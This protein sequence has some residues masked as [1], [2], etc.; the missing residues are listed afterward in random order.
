MKIAVIGAGAAGFFG[1]LSCAHHFPEHEII[2]FEKTHKLL[3]KVKISGG[4]RCNVTNSKFDINQLHEFY[5]RGAKELKKTFVQFNHLDTIKWFESRGVEIIAEADG[6]M[7]PKSNSSQTIIDCLTD[8]VK[9]HN[10]SIVQGT[11]LLSV[12]LLSNN[13]FELMFSNDNKYQC[14]RILIATG[15]NSHNSAYDWLRKLN[16]KIQEPVPSLFTFN[17][18]DTIM[19]GLQGVV[20]KNAVVKIK[21]TKFA[22]QGITLITHWGYSG[23][24]VLR[25]SAWAARALHEMNYQCKIHINWAGEKKEEEIRQEFVLYKSKHPSKLVFGN[26]MFDLPR[27]LWERLC[28]QNGIQEKIKW[29]ELPNKLLNKLIESICNDVYDM[30]GKTTFKEEFVTA[31][32]VDLEQIDMHT[33]SSKKHSGIYFAGEVLD[34]DGIT[35]GFNFQAAWATGWV[36]GKNIG[37]L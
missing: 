18:P 2:I 11:G 35:G 21:Q 3:S 28:E 1:A 10:I 29:A 25:L 20:V 23:P 9:K 34:I 36:A 15:G 22:E 7:F 32:G 19:Q 13:Q 8:E 30:K 33:M 17:I 16:I 5:P 37:L 24:A 26:P 27:R 12:E 31:G 4:G 14:D 6:R